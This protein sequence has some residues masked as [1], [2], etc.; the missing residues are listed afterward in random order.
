[1]LLDGIGVETP[2]E[3][4]MIVIRNTDQ[5]GVIGD[6]GTILGKHHVNI[7]NFALGRQGDSAVGVVIVDE[8][9]EIRRRCSTRFGRVKGS[10]KSGWCGCNGARERTARARGDRSLI[11]AHEPS[12][13]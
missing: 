5:P 3:G 6:I 2:L 12:S 7:A 10:G 9:A 4:T 1:V 8:T 13:T 11:G